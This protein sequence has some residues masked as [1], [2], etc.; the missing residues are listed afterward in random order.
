[1]KFR[2]LFIIFLA[3]SSIPVAAKVFRVPQDF[4]DIGY[5]IKNFAD[6]NDEIIVSPG[7]Y[8]GFDYQSR[9]IN[10]HSI[11]PTNPAIVKT[12]IIK[13][14][15]VMG[16]GGASSSITARLAGFTITGSQSGG[17]AG[18]GKNS[19]IEYCHIYGNEGAQAISGGPSIAGG[20]GGCDGTIRNNVI[21]GN[22]ATLGGGLYK[23][24]GLIENNIIARNRAAGIA[25]GGGSG[26]NGGAALYDCQGI[27]RNNTIVEN[28]TLSVNPD[29]MADTWGGGGLANC[30]GQ[31]YNNIIWVSDPTLTPEYSTCAT[32]RFCCIKGWTGGGQ[33][34]I[35]D[36]PHLTKT[37]FETY[38]VWPTLTGLD[39]H[40]KSD[41]PCI[42]AGMSTSTLTN[43]DFTGIQRG[44]KAAPGLTRGDGSGVDMGAYEAL[45]KPVSV[46]LPDGGPPDIRHG[47]ILNV[48]WQNDPEAGSSARLRLYRGGKYSCELGIFKSDTG[49]S[50]TASV[51]LPVPLITDDTYTIKSISLV[52]NSYASDTAAFKVTGFS[53]NAVPA[54]DWQKYY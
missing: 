51:T 47:Q 10:I 52:S 15:V 13:D 19:I 39:W 30:Q 5:T 35:N 48:C 4:P 24:N 18:G 53:A 22:T 42:D 45:P 36:D 20:I 25:W 1:M 9:N 7:T 21:E 3:I 46:W 23:C 40:I 37:S 34:N 33:G 6:N 14:S 49:T 11:D 28:V 38:R 31:I 27:I 32:P 44:L 12:T 43:H 41:S 2:L 16:D 50:G 17:V 54:H 26:G 29:T 8:N